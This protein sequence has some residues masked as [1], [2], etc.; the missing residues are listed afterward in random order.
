[1]IEFVLLS[2]I[3]WSASFSSIILSFKRDRFFAS[4]FVCS[5]N[6]ISL[7]SFHIRSRSMMKINNLMKIDVLDFFKTLTCLRR[8]FSILRVFTLFF[9]HFISLH[10]S[11]THEICIQFFCF[12]VFF[13]SNFSIIVNF[14]FFLISFI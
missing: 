14:A 6:H 7:M 1:M 9:L 5:I 11:H 10:A 3:S 4:F 12:R 8:A 13:R 2:Y